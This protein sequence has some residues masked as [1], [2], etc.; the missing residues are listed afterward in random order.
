MKKFNKAT[1]AVISGAAVAILGAL[2]EVEPTVLVS[3]QTLITT[4]LVW[5]V[6]NAKA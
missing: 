2:I 3:I 4:A 6:P 5:L 1:A